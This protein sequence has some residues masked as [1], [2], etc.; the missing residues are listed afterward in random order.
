MARKL[1][2]TLDFKSL[3]NTGCHL[4]IYK[5]GYTGNTVI[6][7]IGASNPF[8][9]EEDNERDLLHFIRYRTGYIRVIEEN[10]GDLSELSPDSITAHYVV[11]K[12]GGDVVFTGYMQCIELGN[13]WDAGPRV[14]EFPVISPLGLLSA[15]KFTP[16]EN[17]TLTTVGTLMKEVLDTI[18]PYVSG[19][20]TQQG[21]QNV[22]W[23][24][25]TNWPWDCKIHTLVMCP[26]NKDFQ[27]WSTAADIY[28]PRYFQYLVEG[29]C[30]A[31]GW[32]LHDTPASL[33]FSQFDATGRHSRMSVVNLPNPSGRTDWNQ[34]TYEN[35]Y[36]Y[37]FSNNDS[38]YTVRRPLRGIDVSIE[39]DGVRDKML[40]TNH[41]ITHGM[42]QGGYD[43]STL[44]G[45]RAVSLQQVGPS[46]TGNLISFPVI[47][48]GGG[49]QAK[50]VFPYAV[51]FFDDN[52][53]SVSLNESWV[54]HYDSS[55]AASTLLIT[56]K[57]YGLMVGNVNGQTLL[58]LS[59]EY[60]TNLFD[61]K[62]RDYGNV[63]LSMVVKIGDKY[64]NVTTR[65]LSSSI[66][67][68][69]VTIDGSTGSIHPNVTLSD[70]TTTNRLYDAD[71]I[72][73]TPYVGWP[74][75]IFDSIEIS[76]YTT[77]Q[78]SS[79]MAD[80]SYLRI[81]ELALTNPSGPLDE[82]VPDDFHKI[83]V[84]IDGNHTGTETAGITANINNYADCI[85]EHSLMNANNAIT[86]S[87]PQYAYMFTP[88]M[89]I[90][91]SVKKRRSDV[92]GAIEYVERWIAFGDSGPIWR[93]ISRSFCL[94]N[95]EYRVI[96]AR[97]RTLSQQ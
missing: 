86:G 22:I 55:W 60:G 13:N 52:D 85:C 24:G 17:P 21:Y 33:V 59:A 45:F 26:F 65:Q 20:A 71:G 31:F 23:P 88:Q 37:Q 89:F 95:D 92:P 6:E 30:N 7:L 16:P 1:R 5:E 72:L 25:D 15:F 42:P 43:A 53:T 29:I 38:S 78:T 40:N 68:N 66:I 82:F 50:G 4:D 61:M 83:L 27:H 44:R 54:I 41:A 57:F 70:G 79:T 48:G 67:Y 73:I 81:T 2:W 39:G 18:N 34:D 77:S 35:E 76:L 12:Y 36:Y 51:G 10:Y 14:L 62:S 47:D 94:W 28:S 91:A 64:L 49:I 75:N 11:A 96:F 3:N 46:V 84:R 9:Y 56:A 80:G 63:Q 74:Q 87:C 32:M 90:E 8:E 69:P 58:K 19:D 97:T 93:I